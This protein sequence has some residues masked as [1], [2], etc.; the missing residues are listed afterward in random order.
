[1]A[2][3]EP[4]RTKVGDPIKPDVGDV[5]DGISLT[6]SLAG[7]DEGY[8]AINRATGQI[9]VKKTLNFEAPAD[10]DGQCTALNAC[11]VT[12]TATGAIP[13]GNDQ[14]GTATITITVDDVNEAPEYPQTATRYVVENTADDK[15][16]GNPVRLD[17]DG[18]TGATSPAT[19]AVAATDPDDDRRLYTLG[20]S[21]AMYFA[22]YKA[23]GQVITKKLLDYESL[24]ANDKTYD[25]TVTATDSKGLS[26]TVNLTI[27]VVDVNEAPTT[28]LGDLSVSGSASETYM[29]NGAVAVGTYEAQG[30]NAASARWTLEGA[31]SGDFRI[32][33]A[34][35]LTFRTSPNYE[36]PADADRDNVYM[37]TVKAA[38]G[39]EMDTIT[40]TITV[41]DVDDTTEPMTLLDRYDA[42]DNGEI[43]L[44]EVFQAIDDYFDYDD[45][46][47]LEQ[48]NEIVDLY[49]EA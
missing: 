4:V 34:G 10:T 35:V 36:S 32:S 14:T 23:T 16:L 12:V 30:E 44:D 21:D 29:E 33:S 5:G 17:D 11:E 18:D 24:P 48:I 25:V 9:T 46:L 39:G 7:A 13:D 2:E 28:T 37:V 42:D 41:T 26:D 22:I 8:F 6:Y 3:N 49:F 15:V 40:V 31:D 1:M 47:T 19:D 27:E 20:G 45:R 43:E 38:A